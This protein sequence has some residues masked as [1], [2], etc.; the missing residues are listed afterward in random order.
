MTS[1][2]QRLLLAEDAFLCAMVEGTSAMES[3]D[4]QWAALLQDVEGGIQSSAFDEETIELARTTALRIAVFAESFESLQA[5]CQ[6]L[7]SS[8][9]DEVDTI[10]SRMT[11]SDTSSP[12]HVSPTI[13]AAGVEYIYDA[14]TLSSCAVWWLQPFCASLHI[15][16]QSIH[17]SVHL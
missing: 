2:R 17:L 15:S 10:L 7:T 4:R 11:I 1:I 3:F 5:K 14:C 9:M 12:S 13:T 8:M 16:Q 6:V